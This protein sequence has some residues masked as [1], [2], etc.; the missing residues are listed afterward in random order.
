ITERKQA[1]AALRH[2][3][4]LFRGVAGAAMDAIVSAGGDGV[5]RSWNRGAERMFGWAAAEVVGRPLT[6]IIPERLRALHEAG[7]A[8]VAASGESKLA[9]QVV[10]LTAV[11]RDG[12]E[13]PVELS[14]GVWESDEGMMFSGVIRDITERKQAEDA[15]AAANR[16]LERANAELETL[17]Y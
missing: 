12:G 1:E 15:I 5:L 11:R 14:I 6:V 7:I 13:F 16:E 10:E 8:R 9:G 2:S 17:V 3:E 4:G